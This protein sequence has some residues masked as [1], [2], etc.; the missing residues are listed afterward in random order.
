MINVNP[1]IIEIAFLW[2]IL[3]IFKLAP[4]F[5]CIIVGSKYYCPRCKNSK[6]IEYTK[7][8]ECTHCHLEFEKK[9]FNLYDDSQILAV[10]EKSSFI[11]FFEK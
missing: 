7:T 5:L 11:K 4:Y 1:I 3:A 9:D 8:I 6:I 10:Q 2:F